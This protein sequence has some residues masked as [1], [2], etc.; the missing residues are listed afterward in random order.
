MNTALQPFCSGDYSKS[1]ARQSAPSRYLTWCNRQEKN[2]FI[3]KIS[4]LAG[5]GC[6]ITPITLF[7]I[8]I[9]GN[10]ILLWTLLMTALAM[11]VVANL[12][13]LAVKVII[14]LLFLSVLIDLGVILS[15]IITGLPV[16]G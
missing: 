8:I 6:F 2:R 16:T 3:W 9:N 13:A 10:S 4:G 11:T 15:C 1:I 14:P 7:A 5:Q 12:A